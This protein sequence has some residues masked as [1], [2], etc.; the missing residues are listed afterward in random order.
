M[1]EGDRKTSPSTDLK[2]TKERAHRLK[3]EQRVRVVGS[4]FVSVAAELVK[5]S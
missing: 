3:A 5:Q 1:T 2:P 4:F